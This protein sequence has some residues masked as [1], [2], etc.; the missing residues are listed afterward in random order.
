MCRVEAGVHRLVRLSP[1]DPK[2]RRHTSFAQVYIHT[3]IHTHIHT[4][5]EMCVCVCVCVCMGGSGGAWI[6]DVVAF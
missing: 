2:E 6:G 5:V 4:H 1:F 3:Y